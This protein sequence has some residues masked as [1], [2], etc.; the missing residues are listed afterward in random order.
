MSS[1]EYN[2]IVLF[3]ANW[4]GHCEHFLPEWDK[5][6][7]KLSGSSIK[8]EEYEDSANKEVM[9]KNK[10]EGFPTIRIYTAN[11]KEGTDYNGPRIAN[12]I[13]KFLTEKSVKN[14]NPTEF[15]QCGGKRKIP[16][17]KPDYNDNDDEYKLKYFKYKAKYMKLK[18]QNL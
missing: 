4:C 1:N 2:K 3:R 9:Q 11:D 18:A 15:A 7:K 5:L 12:D 16:Q 13:Y 8:Y 10:I 6:K 14:K 17:Y